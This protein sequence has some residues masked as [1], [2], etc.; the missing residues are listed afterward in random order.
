MLH[1]EVAEM[2]AWASGVDGRLLNEMSVEAW[3]QIV[4]RFDTADVQQAVRDH[5]TEVSRNIYPADVVKRLEAALEV[6]ALPSGT[7][8][9]LAEQKAAWCRE[10]KVTVEE[11]DAHQDDHEWIRAVQRG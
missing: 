6:V 9:L 5:Y 7:A 3:H 2:L 11:F 8:E 10:H 1:S 4:G